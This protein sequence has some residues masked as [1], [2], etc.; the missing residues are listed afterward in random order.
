LVV[1]LTSVTGSY[2]ENQ[3]I[4]AI[5]L[6]LINALLMMLAPFHGVGANTKEL[7]TTRQINNW[8]TLDI[9]HYLL[10]EA[11]KPATP[12]ARVEI[13]IRRVPMNLNAVDLAHLSDVPVTIDPIAFAQ[14]KNKKRLAEMTAAI[15]AIERGY[16]EHVTLNRDQE[17][18]NARVYR[19]LVL[20]LDWYR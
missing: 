16:R 5:K 7:P 1:K 8:Q 3:F 6:R 12:K 15:E 18:A 14:L 10:G 4:Y 19:K 17:T 13:D 11:F 9:H 20:S 2:Y